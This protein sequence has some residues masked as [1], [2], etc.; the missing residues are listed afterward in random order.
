MNAYVDEESG[1]VVIETG[2]DVVQEAA[3]GAVSTFSGDAVMPGALIDLTTRRACLGEATDTEKIEN[4]LLESTD[5]PATG[6][7]TSTQ[8]HGVCELSSCDNVCC[9]AISP[10]CLACSYCCSEEEYCSQIGDHCDDNDGNTFSH[11]TSLSPQIVAAAAA[12]ATML[13][14]IN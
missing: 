10:S 11:A 4:C 6:A 1:G 9:Q 2:G 12:M 5:A 8:D 3:S 7:P 14:A 13:G